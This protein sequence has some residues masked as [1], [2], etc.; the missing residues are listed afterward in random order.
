[1]QEQC[2]GRE[3]MRGCEKRLNMN[4]SHYIIATYKS[5]I[6]PLFLVLFFLLLVLTVPKVSI[7]FTDF[8]GGKLVC[9][10]A[11]NNDYESTSHQTLYKGSQGKT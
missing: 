10:F 11:E 2:K 7:L 8:I 5:N 6:L 4:A 3:I 1:M 9:I